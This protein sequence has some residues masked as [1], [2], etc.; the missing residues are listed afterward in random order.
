MKRKGNYW[1]WPLHAAIVAAGGAALLAR[2]QSL[3]PSPVPSVHATL[4]PTTAIQVPLRMSADQTAVWAENLDQHMLL[5]GR[6]N[7]AVG[8][9]ML[10]ADSASVLLTPA[11]ESG[12]NAYDVAIFLS[13]NVVVREGTSAG[14]TTTAGPELLVT[15]RIMQS[16]QLMGLPVAR[17]EQNSAIAKRGEEIRRQVLGHALAPM[18]APQIVITPAEQALQR[19]WIA[20]GENNRIIPGPGD[21]QWVRNE[22]GNLVP[23]TMPT[24][25]GQVKPRP[26][27]FATGDDIRARQI[28]K[29]M[30]TVV[31]GAYMLYDAQ[32][33]RPPLE[34]RAQRMVVFSPMAQATP[35]TGTAPAAGAPAVPPPN[36]ELTQIATGVYLEGDV[37]L[38]QG[39]NVR[40]RAERVYYDFTSQRA[41]ML[42]AT[43]ST[44]EEKREV[45]VYLRATEI[46]QMARGEWAAKN[47][48]FSTSEFYTPHYHIGA[49]EAYLRDITPQLEAP[50]A[51]EEPGGIGAAFG[52]GRSFEASTYQ[53]KLK[54]TTLDVGGVPIFYWPFLAGDTAKNEIPLRTV[55]VSNSRTYGLSL[56][57]DWDIFGLAGQTAPEGVRADLSLDYFGK[58]GPA[59]GVQADWKTDDDHG[60]LRTYAIY[61]QGTDRLGRD[62]DD[63]VPPQEARGRATLRDQRDLGNGLTLQLEGAYLSDPNFLEQF[64][65]REFDADKQ[66]ETSIYLKKQDDTSALT[67]LGKFNLM[68][69]TSSADLID[70]QFMTE[71][72]PEVKYWR[73]G[74]SFLD[75]FTYYSETSGSNLHSDISDYTPRSLG[76]LPSFL[77]PPANVVPLD[78]TYRDYYRSRGW[79]SGNAL[80]GDTRHELDM[81]LQFGDAK[82]TPYITGRATFWDSDFPDN[83]GTTG[84]LWGGA[85]IRS[86]MQF[87]RVY[88]D[89]RSTFFDV[90]RIRHVIEP[91]FNLFVGGSTVDRADLQPFDRDVEGI[92]GGSGMQLAFNQKWQTKRGAEGHQHDVDWI[93][94]NVSWSQFWNKDQTNDLLYYTQTP[95][96]GFYFASRPELS[97]VQNAI[98][99]DGSWRFGERARLLG[100]ANYSLDTHHVE[101]SAVGIAI[102][103][104]KSLSYFVGNRYIRALHTNEWTFALDY[105]LTQKYQ[106]IAAESYDFLSGNNILTSVTIVRKLPRFHTALTITYDANNA[107]TSVVFTA[108]PEGFPNTGFGSQYAGSA[109][110]RQ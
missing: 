39:N 23:T 10:Q 49:S 41:I 33:G 80:R 63:I 15:T 87:W 104:T 109:R 18:Y 73:I 8:Y 53:F 91:Q 16:V 72:M 110:E 27:V 19:G 70:D 60:V 2:A 75:L 3:E 9:R 83:G 59:G 95:V 81:P 71:K 4:S 67:L 69:F 30:V 78:T 105:Q 85:G 32:D 93:T 42:D 86:S 28:D 79:N 46:R 31:P 94:L 34:F 103:Q 58:R 84:R 37:T 14:S 24:L 90:N 5:T 47:V 7:I 108:W 54:D 36:T 88:D 92:S 50:N 101:Q 35:A 22:Q 65:Q 38:D 96:R 107:D 45:P 44:V 102:D 77:G 26:N 13:G 100:E 20:R 17:N 61:D 1:R 68:D 55:R 11:R 6:V 51:G 43:L 64:F 12:T 29:E 48:K 57:T 89:A 82:V 25:P 66:E 56:L 62:R 40:V 99:V 21:I 97:L 74:D 52:G 98:N 76:L 106:F